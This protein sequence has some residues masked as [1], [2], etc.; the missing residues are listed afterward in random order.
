VAV[1]A[2]G[3]SWPLDPPSESPT[4]IG[5]VLKPLTGTEKLA[6]A[7]YLAPFL[8]GPPVVGYML[9]GTVGAVG[10]AILAA[11]AIYWVVG[12]LRSM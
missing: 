11:P 4:K 9:L 2:A 6:A 7:A 5:Y 10:G 12:G 3:E 8:L 1:G